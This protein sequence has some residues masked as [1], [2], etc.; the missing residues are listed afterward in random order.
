MF[1]VFDNLFMYDFTLAC[2]ERALQLADDHTA[3]DVWCVCLLRCTVYV[4]FFLQF[5]NRFTDVGITFRIWPSAWATW[6]WRDKP[7]RESF[8]LLFSIWCCYVCQQLISNVCRVSTSF[9]SSHAVSG[10]SFASAYRI[11]TT[12][13]GVPQQPRRPGAEARQEGRSA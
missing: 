3:A 11:P 7:S 8:E 10:F 2:F 9:D 6:Q 1:D 12:R 4:C 13:L 5:V